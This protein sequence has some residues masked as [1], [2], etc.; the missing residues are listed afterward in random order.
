MN[1]VIAPTEIDYLSNIVS[2]LRQPL[3][4]INGQV[5]LAMG[6]LEADPHRALEALGEAATQ[7][8]RIDRL[9]VELRDRARDRAHVEALFKA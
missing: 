1:R 8:T 7:L 6:S 2:E 5:Q 9:L 3:T 4:V